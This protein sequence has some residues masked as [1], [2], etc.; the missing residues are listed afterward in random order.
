MILWAMD[1][2]VIIVT[3]NSANHIAACLQSVLAQRGVT[4]E[5]IV[6]DNASS[7]KTLAQIGGFNVRVIANRENLGFGRG[8]NLGFGSSAGRYVYFL[9]PDARLAQ[10]DALA[11]LCAAMDA[12][13]QWGMAGTRVLDSADHHE[14]RPAT[15]YPAQ[16]HVRRD[17]SKLP[18]KIAWIIG[19]SMVVRRE[20]Y[21]KQGG[22]DPDFFLYSEET[23]FCLRMRELG[24]EI[25]HIPEVVVEH[26]GGA[27]EDL[28]DPYVVS[29]N[30]LKG[31]L[32]F[33]QKHYP[34]EDCVFLAKRDLR[35]ARFRMFWNGLLAKLQPPHAKAWQKHRQYRGVLDVSRQYLSSRT[36][37]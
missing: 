22:F 16:R 3:Y 25:G 13:P 7:D 1:I 17:F 23:D 35:R 36:D 34:P 18:G 15:E 9:N 11:K 33:R 4:L 32:R 20:L 6:V 19:A 29:A 26:I 2:S 24:F 37:S 27:S 10:P 12:N 30:K 21:Q 8:N 5:I 31:L 28:R 14:C